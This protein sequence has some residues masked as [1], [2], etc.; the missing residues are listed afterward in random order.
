MSRQTRAHARTAA[1][2][3]IAHGD[4][5]VVSSYSSTPPSCTRRWPSSETAGPDRARGR[6][7]RAPS[8]LGNNPT[9]TTRFVSRSCGCLLTR[10]IC[11]P[12]PSRT[13]VD[14]VPNPRSAR[15]GRSNRRDSSFATECGTPGSARDG[16]RPAAR[17]RL[18]IE[19]RTRRRRSGQT[20]PRCSAN[21]P[22]RGQIPPPEPKHYRTRRVGC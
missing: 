20:C 15:Q 12:E 6:A 13:V 21:R 22:R 8:E 19:G 7:A 5:P 10:P 4:A 9:R 1:A 2:P 3:T 11:G 14:T 16:I 17:V 18:P